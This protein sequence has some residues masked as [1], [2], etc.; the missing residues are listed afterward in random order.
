MNKSVSKISV[1][2]MYLSATRNISWRRNGPLE[3]KEKPLKTKGTLLG[4][5]RRRGYLFETKQTPREM[6]CNKKKDQ[7]LA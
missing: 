6:Q 7:K 4:L 2:K 1:G 5:N 3:M